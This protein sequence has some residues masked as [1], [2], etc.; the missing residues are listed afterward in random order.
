MLVSE[1]YVEFLDFRRSSHLVLDAET[2]FRECV[3]NRNTEHAVLAKFAGS[4]VHLPASC[5]QSMGDCNRD[6]FCPPFK[7]SCV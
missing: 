1:M 4:K 6:T 5:G 3:E 7:Y 2:E